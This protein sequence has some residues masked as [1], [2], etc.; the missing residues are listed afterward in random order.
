MH[1]VFAFLAAP[2]VRFHCFSF[3]FDRAC[4]A[5]PCVSLP[6]EPVCS[7]HA[8]LFAFPW[9]TSVPRARVHS[10][11][12]LHLCSFA[13]PL[14]RD[15]NRWSRALAASSWVAQDTPTPIY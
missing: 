1:V 9:L 3:Y 13:L 15:A 11:F 6:I 12:S 5:L 2:V 14:L 10:Y 4:I 7:Q 8:E